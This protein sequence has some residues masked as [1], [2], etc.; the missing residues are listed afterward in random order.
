[1]T[2]IRFTIYNLN[3]I[4]CVVV[5]FSGVEILH[6]L[7]TIKHKHIY[8]RKYESTDAKKYLNST[9]YYFLCCQH[10]CPGVQ[11]YKSRLVTSKSLEK[12]PFPAQLL[13]PYCL[14]EK[15][16]VSISIISPSQRSSAQ[17]PCHTLLTFWAQTLSSSRLGKLKTFYLLKIISPW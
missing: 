1:M 9:I 17:W 15:F 13:C 11:I 2:M 12:S 3:R 7:D 14:E 10:K 16:E 5:L 4:C 6:H 8:W